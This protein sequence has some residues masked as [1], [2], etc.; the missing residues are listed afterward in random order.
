MR[1][2]QRAI[3]GRG[4]KHVRMVELLK[5]CPEL[6]LGEVNRLRNY[7]PK[8][9]IMWMACQMAFKGMR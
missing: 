2:A 9:S 7:Q 4:L 8:L 6:T 5:A 3:E 1:A